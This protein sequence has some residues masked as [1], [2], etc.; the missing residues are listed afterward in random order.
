MVCNDPMNPGPWS[1]ADLAGQRLLVGFQG[2]RFDPDLRALIRSFRPAGVIL[3][4]RNIETPQQIRELTASLQDFAA[5]IGI[6]PLFVAVDQE[7]GRVAR[8][9]P[10]FTQ[11]PETPP[12]ASPA[13]AERFAAIT[14]AELNAVGINMNLAPVLDVAP[15]GF[16][17][18]MEG[19]ALGSDPQVV[20]RLG[21]A[22]I[23]GLQSRGIL[24]V[25]KHFPGIGRTRLDSHEDLPVL[26]EDLDSLEAFELPPFRAAADCGV[27]GIMISHI[28]YPRLDP[29][30]PASL[31]AAVAQGLLRRRLGYG[32]LSLT[33]D[34]NMGA[35]ARAFSFEEA[36]RRAFRAGVDLLLVCRD[37][38]RI[39][40]AHALLVEELQAGNMRMRQSA[41]ESIER[42]LAAKRAL[43]PQAKGGALP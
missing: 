25:A 18:V 19:R 23:R 16:G 22:V 21:V 40:R 20:A 27:A 14:A 43:S 13:E 29:A 34:L 30:Q 35:V 38:E 6:P 41:S 11:F 8:L 31:S 36:V 26:A 39:A 32:G 2:V 28:L 5:G 42:I 37:T 33:D 12:I 17:S 9:P 7:G 4:R 1:I 15:E 3:F 10:P 24:S